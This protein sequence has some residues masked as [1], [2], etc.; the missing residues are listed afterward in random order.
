MPEGP[1]PLTKLAPPKP[2][3]EFDSLLFPFFRPRN[4]TTPLGY[5]H[6]GCQYDENR[7]IRTSRCLFTSSSHWTQPH[8][9]AWLSLSAFS[10]TMREIKDRIP[11]F[12]ELE[13][14][15]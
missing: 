10:F 2:I 12:E 9:L 15:M 6:L 5:G 7:S 4:W 13:G 11:A 8:K 3:L 1:M 14:T